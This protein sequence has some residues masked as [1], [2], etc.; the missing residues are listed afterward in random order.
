MATQDSRI[1]LK[2]STVAGATPTA[3]PS[4]DHTDG[5]WSVNDVYIG[6]LYLN[7]ADQRLF[8]RTS[9]GI[10]ELA[11]GSG[12]LKEAQLTLTTAQVLA[13]NTTPITIIAGQTGKE[14]QVLSASI[15]LKYNTTAYA[16]NTNMALKAAST[17]AT[18]TQA[19]IDISQTSDTL[20]AFAMSEV[21]NNIVTGDALQV[22][23][24][25]GD[26]TAGDSDIVVNILYRITD[27]P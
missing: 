1:R 12:Q 18:I 14:I 16:T 11:T 13:L 5:T 27:L 26:P 4:T 20:G 2:R 22:T 21:N 15:H 17:G 7:D 6:E 9:T 3:A 25:T 23:V 8:V 19:R 24:L 10:V